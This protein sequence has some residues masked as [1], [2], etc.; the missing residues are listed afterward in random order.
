MHEQDKAVRRRD[1]S[2][3][4]A[5]LERRAR[6]RIYRDIVSTGRAPRAEQV[7]ARMKRPVRDIRE[8]FE[9][10]EAGHAI[11]LEKDTREILR[12]APFWASP[13]AFQVESGR[14]SWWASCIWDALGVPAMLGRDARILTACGCCGEAMTLRVRRGKIERARGV[15]HFAVPARRWYED[16]VFT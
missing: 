5:S 6:L 15:I 4:F 16:L 2:T 1:E 3:A 8:S 9:R 12:A 13:T 10:L 7:A 11:T 14:R